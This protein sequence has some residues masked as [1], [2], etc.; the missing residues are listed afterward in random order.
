MPRGWVGL[1]KIV[2]DRGDAYLEIGAATLAISN[3]VF[4]PRLCD[5][6]V[7]PPADSEGT[8]EA[9]TD[10]VFLSVMRPL[11]FLNQIKKNTLSCSRVF[12]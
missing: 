3:D 1:W 9:G 2:G 5:L 11:D 10:S 7:R 4:F 8:L 6:R 12:R